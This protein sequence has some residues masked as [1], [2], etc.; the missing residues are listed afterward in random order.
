VG[1]DIVLGHHAAFPA[2]VGPG[3]PTIP[4][5]ERTG[6]LPHDGLFVRRNNAFGTRP[7]P[8]IVEL[9]E[10]GVLIGQNQIRFD[11]FVADDTTDVPAP[12]GADGSGVSAGPAEVSGPHKAHPETTHFVEIA[13]KAAEQP[14]PGTAAATPVPVNFVFVVDV[15]SSM[16]GSKLDTVKGSIR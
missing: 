2:V 14:P 9:I 10:Q 4:V 11:D 12:A 16:A 15:S 1:G 5:H 13:L 6:P 8:G 7:T 3:G